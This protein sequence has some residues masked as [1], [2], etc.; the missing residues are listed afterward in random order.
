[1]IA[2]VDA[3]MRRQIHAGNLIQGKERKNLLSDLHLAA[4]SAVTAWRTDLDASL[5][6]AG[7][8]DTSLISFLLGRSCFDEPDHRLEDVIGLLAPRMDLHLAVTE[9]RDAL[10][11]RLAPVY[12]EAEYRLGSRIAGLTASRRSIDRVK[13]SRWAV[14]ARSAFANA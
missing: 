1:V 14:I 7:S 5:P 8:L 6:V 9:A 4:R 11:A 13:A 10:N 2:A 3:D 12:A